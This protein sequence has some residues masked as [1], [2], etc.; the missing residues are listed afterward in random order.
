MFQVSNFSK[1]IIEFTHSSF[2]S[3]DFTDCDFPVET[4]DFPLDFMAVAVASSVE[5]FD[6]GWTEDQMKHFI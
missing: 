4:G 3:K 5:V 2:C 1:R 6:Q